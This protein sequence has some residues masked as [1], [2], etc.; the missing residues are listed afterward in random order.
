M[1]FS[2]FL[3]NFLENVAY[4]SKIL[5]KMFNKRIILF[6]Y[7]G[8]AY[9]VFN[10]TEIWN[11]ESISGLLDSLISYLVNIKK[12]DLDIERVKFLGFGNGGNIL[13]YFICTSEGA[14]TS[15]H[16]TLLVNSFSYLDELLYQT[17]QECI[18]N[19]ENFPDDLPELPYCYYWAL[20][21]TKPIEREEVIKRVKT[22]P[23]TPKSRVLILKG[24]YILYFLLI[25]VFL[26]L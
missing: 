25:I 3:D 7:P 11:N 9:T 6:N 23:L 2:L 13:T 12:I 19:F 22:N 18:T 14:M 1:I 4:F 10:E 5:R 21:C 24:I 15:L 8:Q 20:A 16:S 26:K 17:L